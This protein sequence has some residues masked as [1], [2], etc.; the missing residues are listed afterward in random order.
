MD[1]DG[2]GGE[3]GGAE[4]GMGVER[5][6]EGIGRAFGSS[7]WKS[8]SVKLWFYFYWKIYL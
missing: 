7:S 4:G 3:G 6:G 5:A 1:D 2:I 8:V